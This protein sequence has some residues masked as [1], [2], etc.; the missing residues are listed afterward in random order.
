MQA[1]D[2]RDENWVNAEELLP[3][4]TS[5]GG[6][7]W[8]SALDID[9]C[10]RVPRNRVS[11]TPHALQG[12]S[13]VY[14]WNEGGMFDDR[15]SAPI[16][17]RKRYRPCIYIYTYVYPL[18]SR[19]SRRS[20]CLVRIT[21]CQLETLLFK[22]VPRSG[23]I[24]S[25]RNAISFLLGDR[26]ASSSSLKACELNFNRAC[27]RAA[28]EFRANPVIT[29]VGILIFFFFGSVSFLSCGLDEWILP[30]LRDIYRTGQVV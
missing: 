6:L 3:I 16:D 17:F 20:F 25:N 22:A 15:M 4:T 13:I 19:S 5:S 21:N 26:R 9:P 11:F 1:G 28:F 18:S 24:Y 12:L 2:K 27:V 14:R 30:K 29:Y 8:S 7:V 23:H 10:W